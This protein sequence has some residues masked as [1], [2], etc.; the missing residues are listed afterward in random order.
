M[1]CKYYGRFIIEFAGGDFRCKFDKF[2][3]ARVNGGRGCPGPRMR[4][5]H[6]VNTLKKR[7]QYEYK[8]QTRQA[9]DIFYVV[10][11]CLL[12]TFKFYNLPVIS[13]K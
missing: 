10:F 12:P 1:K 3:F 5:I 6:V 11:L 9:K 7:R 13:T 2:E 4:Y 8:I